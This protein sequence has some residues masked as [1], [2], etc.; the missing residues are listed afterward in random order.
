[1]IRLRADHKDWY[2]IAFCDFPFLLLNFVIN[3]EVPVL[4]CK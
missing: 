2:F 4:N 3:C 1:V